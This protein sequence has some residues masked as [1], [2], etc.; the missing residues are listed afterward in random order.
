MFG[1]VWPDLRVAVR[2]LLRSPGF[3]LTAILTL[4]AGMS[5]TTLVFTVIN[6]VLLR[7]LPVNEPERLIAVST[8]GEMAFLQQEP[9]TFSDYQDL[10]REVP[11]FESVVAHRRAPSVVGAGADSRV[12][13]GENVS[14]NYFTALGV[15]L[16]RGR[17]FTEDD[18]PDT[19]VVLSH[20]V[21]R[22]RFGRDPRLIG[23]DIELGGR[24]RTVVGVAP[25]GFTGL[26]R[27]IAPEF[28]IPIRQSAVARADNR[29]TLQ[30]WVH[31]RLRRDAGIEQAAAQV[32]GAARTLAERYPDTNAGRTYRLDRL[33][34]ASVH[35]AV[36]KALVTGGALGVLGVALLVL[37]VASVNV[38][39]LVLARAAIRQREIA[40][41]TAIGATQWRIVRQLLAEG[42]VLAAGAATVA[43][44]IA[45]W[46]GRALSAVPLPVA[47]GIDL[48]L[49]PDWRVFAFT[50][51]VALLTA[52][53]FSVGPAVR[54]ARQPVSVALSND[55]RTSS[56]AVGVRWRT[57][58]LSAQA[59][60]ATLLLVLGGL[61]LRS[62]AATT[63]VEPGFDSERVIVAAA[64][65]GLVEYDR[66]RALAFM[67]AAAA[68]VRRLPGAQSAGWM[69]PVPLS[70]NIR[71]TRLRLPGQ[72]G[73]P[74]R[75]LPFVD[76]AIAWPGAFEA[77]RI[78]V[79]AGREFTDQDRSGQTGVALVNEEFA[80]RYWPG[81]RPIGQRIAAGF[82][83]TAN[84]E[85]LGDFGH[86]ARGKRSAG[87]AGLP[88]GSHASSAN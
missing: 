16:A 36:P 66:E 42:V 28:W 63:R 86:R 33:T 4:A 19:V 67:T 77:L 8:A 10:A 81:L 26:F 72:E 60:V 59:A 87:V 24:S 46:A 1:T 2:L 58:L 78:P 48:H 13:L 88:I 45:T 73:V 27:G 52:V 22:Q 57:M 38:A 44:I 43:L 65:P 83:D 12:A 75:E 84:L 20:S 3:S 82:P 41:R 25:E 29:T 7:P 53:L 85:I 9:L 21:W 51:A 34:D 31:A 56:S 50:G 49:T 69:H 76:A 70:L 17:P 15:R 23:R 64:S 61:A 32:A 30:W 39:N 71:I 37:I 40:I 68:R 47:I 62:L 55:G 80:R 6:A 18:D 5:A 11:A 54:A 79:T 74:T 14:G 35:P